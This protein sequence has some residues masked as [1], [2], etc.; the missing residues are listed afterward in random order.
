MRATEVT[1]KM[2]Q[3]L[4]DEILKDESKHHWIGNSPYAA[5][6][7][8]EGKATLTRAFRVG[9]YVRSYHTDGSL[10][11]GY[12]YLRIP[13]KRFA[14]WSELE[15]YLRATNRKYEEGV[16]KERTKDETYEAK[17]NRERESTKAG[18]TQFLRK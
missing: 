16:A 11:Y 7:S 9:K 10:T 2:I 5:S 17:L 12:E 8:Q 14:S 4:K 6:V 3:K 1:E 13:I 18:V 15:V